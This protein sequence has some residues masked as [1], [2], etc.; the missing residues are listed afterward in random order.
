M[1]IERMPK[2]EVAKSPEQVLIDAL[3]KEGLNEKTR[4]ILIKYQESQE[5]LIEQRDGKEYELGQMELNV[6]MARLYR[7]A[8]LIEMA[9][10]SYDDV[11]NQMWNYFGKNLPEIYYTVDEEYSALE[12]QFK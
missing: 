6:K 8:G 1:S 5:A 2:Y 3:I 12:K 11:L 4:A 7:D 10:E 9:L